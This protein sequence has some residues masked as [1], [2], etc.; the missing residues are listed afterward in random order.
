MT[1]STVYNHIC[2]TAI[3]D[4]QSIT[5]WCAQGEMLIV[6]MLA[7]IWLDYICMELGHRGQPENVGPL[8]W[9]ALRAL[10]AK[11]AD[12]FTEAFTLMQNGQLA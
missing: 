1:P 2:S 3:F 7:G 9:R 6:V 4:F 11:S 8:H 12:H 10:D 5:F